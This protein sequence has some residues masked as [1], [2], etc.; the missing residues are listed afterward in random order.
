MRNVAVLWEK[1]MNILSLSYQ[2]SMFYDAPNI[3]N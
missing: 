3:I 2:N 1:N